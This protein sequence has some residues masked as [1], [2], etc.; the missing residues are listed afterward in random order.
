MDSRQDWYP[1]FSWLAGVSDRDDAPIKPLPI[2]PTDPTK[3]IYQN[4]TSFP[5]VDGVNL[6]PFL[7]ENPGA[8]NRSSAHAAL[9]LTKEVVLVG[10]Y[11]LLVAQNVGWDHT[12]DNGWKQPANTTEFPGD[13]WHKGGETWLAPAKTDPCASTSV[14]F[15]CLHGE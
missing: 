1:T 4:F 3:D 2:D 5:S 13:P 14:R 7:L 11:K 8:A 10:K 9:V 6:W 15:S 12:T